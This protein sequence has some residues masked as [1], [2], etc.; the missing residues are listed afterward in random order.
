MAFRGK[1]TNISDDNRADNNSLGR[2]LLALVNG[3]NV[4]DSSGYY[5]HGRP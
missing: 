4:N 3:G 1:E 2:L 5:C